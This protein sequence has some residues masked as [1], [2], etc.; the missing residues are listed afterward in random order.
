MPNQADG[1]SRNF[2]ALKKDLEALDRG[3]EELTAKARTQPL[4][5]SH[6]V[7]QYFAHRYGLNLKSV[8]WEPDDVPDEQQWTELDA[9]LRE[10]PAKWMIWEAPP[11][12]Q[13]EEKLRERGVGCTVFYPCGNVPDGGDYLQTMQGN[14]EALTPVFASR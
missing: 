9:L 7:Y 1:L 12:S 8:H 3:F 6:P 10:H 11:A 14:L 5:A 13:T 4:L 2:E